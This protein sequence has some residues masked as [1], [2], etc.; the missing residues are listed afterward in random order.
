MLVLEGTRS[1]ELTVVDA[2]LA[3]LRVKEAWITFLRLIA[4]FRAVVALGTPV[5]IVV[6]DDGGTGRI[7]LT[8][9]DVASRADLTLAR[10]VDRELTGWA[11]LAR[12]R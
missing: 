1:T 6:I 10:G 8:K 2:F 9:A 12:V 5:T 4:S 7:R 11:S 3:L